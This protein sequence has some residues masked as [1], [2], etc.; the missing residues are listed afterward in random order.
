MSTDESANRR[1]CAIFLPLISADKWLR[2]H[3]GQLGPRAFVARD[4]GAMRIM[5]VDELAEA[6]GIAPGMA[7]ADARAR[8]PDLQTTPYDPASD[9]RWLEELADS[10]DRFTPSVAVDPPDGLTLDITGCA[11]LWGGEAGLM[12]AL[13]AHLV[14]LGLTLRLALAETPDKARALARYGGEM[15]RV[16][17]KLSPRNLNEAGLGY[18]SQPRQTSLQDARTP[19]DVMDLPIHALGMPDEKI[20]ALR[21]AGLRT[22]GD[23]AVRPRAPLAARFGKAMVAQLARILGEEDVRITPRRV[24][25]DISVVHRFADPIGHSDTISATLQSLATAA[26]QQLAQRGKGGRAFALML[27]RSD[28]QVQRLSIGT[29]QATRDPN[30]VLRLFQ[31]RIETLADPLDPGFG[32]DLIRLDIAE[33]EPLEADQLGLGERDT[34]DRALNLLTDRLSVRLEAGRVRRFAAADSHIPECAGFTVPAAHPLLPLAH[35]APV[36]GEPP[37]RPLHLMDPPQ[38]VQVIAEVPDGPPRRFRWRRQVHDITAYEGPERLSAEWW[39]RRDGAGLTRDYYRVEDNA[40]RRFWLFRHGLYGREKD[41][42]DW[43]LHG[44]FG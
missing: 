30:L 7:L 24:P 19:R 39:K 28:G 2:D 37:L 4:K 8:L 44:L 26:V 14:Q 35:H 40:G 1:Y 36:S 31:E 20:T 12:S 42:P 9:A 22:L 34:P 23:L 16:G 32:Y 41:S 29:G 21:R 15:L 38:I 43:Y 3:P 10:C 33:T 17:R 27:F 18:Q 25:P 11:H 5:A 6:L 13:A